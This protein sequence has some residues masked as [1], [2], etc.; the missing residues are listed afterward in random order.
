MFHGVYASAGYIFYFC[1]PHI[2]EKA[3]WVSDVLTVQFG[4][5]KEI[6]KRLYLFMNNVKT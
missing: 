3:T 1:I 5:Y 4:I 2:M 6:L